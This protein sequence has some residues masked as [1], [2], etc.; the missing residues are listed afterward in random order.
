MVPQFPYKE[1]SR[2]WHGLLGVDQNQALC[3]ISGLRG[4]TNMP[5]YAGPLL[6]AERFKACES[7]AGAPEYALAGA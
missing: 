3:P 6:T 5:L 1:L 2:V 7:S 4:L